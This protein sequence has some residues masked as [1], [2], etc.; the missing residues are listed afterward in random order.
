MGKPTKEK[1]DMPPDA[2]MHD[3]LTVRTCVP[4]KPHALVYSH[5]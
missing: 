5:I 3:L 4:R 2:S 1:V